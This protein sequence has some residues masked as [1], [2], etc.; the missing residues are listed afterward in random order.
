MEK[1][2]LMVCKRHFEGS[3]LILS[4]PSLVRGPHIFLSAPLFTTLP[5][6]CCK[7]LPSEALRPRSFPTGETIN[8]SGS[9]TYPL[10]SYI[11]AQINLSLS[12]FLQTKQTNKQRLSYVRFSP[13]LFAQ[14]RRKM[15]FQ[16]FESPL[17][18]QERAPSP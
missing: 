12:A 3:L 14:K 4:F 17:G 5:I 7:S 13:W 10:S 6:L 16:F 8:I 15:T 18:E 9:A 1:S 11:Q 2:L